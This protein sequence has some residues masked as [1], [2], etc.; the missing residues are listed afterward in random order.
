[1]NREGSPRLKGDMQGTRTMS[2]GGRKTGGV[3]RTAESVPRT[4]DEIDWNR[5]LNPNNVF[6]ELP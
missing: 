1:M 3:R 5:R 4:A 2:P 6:D